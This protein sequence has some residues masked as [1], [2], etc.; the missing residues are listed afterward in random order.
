MLASGFDAE[1]FSRQGKS[2]D[3][4][5]AVAENLEGSDRAIDSRGN[6]SRVISAGNGVRPPNSES[7]LHGYRG[8]GV[9]KGALK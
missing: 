9:F 1:K 4:A 8:R 2:G 5:A 6:G 3:L 7:A